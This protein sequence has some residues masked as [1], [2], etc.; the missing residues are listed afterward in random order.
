M[1]IKTKTTK[2]QNI[3]E[4]LKAMFKFNEW[5]RPLIV[6]FFI[7]LTCS[8]WSETPKQKE[9]LE[10]ISQEV[11]VELED[12]DYENATSEKDLIRELGLLVLSVVERY[13]TQVKKYFGID[14]TRNP[15]SR[16]MGEKL[17]RVLTYKCKL[18]WKVMDKRK[19]LAAS[20]KEPSQEE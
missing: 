9:L 10:R 20:E 11:C 13:N 19:E 3:N 18:M 2:Q 12:F 7:G 8:L 17:G 5:L 16:E 14:G 6:C 15:G 1:S 4:K